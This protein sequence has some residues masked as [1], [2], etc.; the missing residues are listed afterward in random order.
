MRKL[1]QGIDKKV[2]DVPPN[3]NIWLFL[4]IPLAVV[5]GWLAMEAKMDI[6]VTVFIYFISSVFF[7]IT[8]YV[9]EKEQRKRWKA[10][11]IAS[12]PLERH[13]VQFI[14]RELDLP[15]EYEESVKNTLRVFRTEVCK[16]TDEF[17][18]V[19][20]G[21]SPSEKDLSHIRNWYRLDSTLSPGESPYV[22]YHYTES[23]KHMPEGFYDCTLYFPK[24]Y[25]L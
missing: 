17:L 6:R 14:S 5:I 18:V 7:A 9:I 22:E 23:S 11:W 13:P 19:S 24:G 16:E 12:L 4:T 15:K 21:K 10:K 20:I 2:K 3:Y 8:V 1:N 25:T